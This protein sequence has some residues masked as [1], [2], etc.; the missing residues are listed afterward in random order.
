MNPHS[1][2]ENQIPNNLKAGLLADLGGPF[3]FPNI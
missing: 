2:N 3:V 1:E